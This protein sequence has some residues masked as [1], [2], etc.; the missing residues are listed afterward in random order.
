MN[1]FSLGV[2]A[3]RNDNGTFDAEVYISLYGSDML[4]TA[5]T[6]NRLVQAG[7]PSRETA[8]HIGTKWIEDNLFPVV[9]KLPKAKP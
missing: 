8:E 6:Q 2:A 4:P 1:T 5:S 3:K 9:K 7:L